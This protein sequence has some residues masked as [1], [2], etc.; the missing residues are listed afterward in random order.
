MPDD[1]IIDVKT[2]V[3]ITKTCEIV[4][5]KTINIYE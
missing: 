5:L 3:K 2:D 4:I 1:I